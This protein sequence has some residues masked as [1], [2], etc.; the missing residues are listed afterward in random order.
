MQHLTP[1]EAMRELQRVLVEKVDIVP[2]GWYT[3]QQLAESWGFQVSHTVRRIRQAQ[4]IGVAESQ[5]FRV[6]TKSGIIRAIPHYRFTAQKTAQD[7]E[8]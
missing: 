8:K 2:E 5:Q 7:L 3:A 4:E 1:A 6:K